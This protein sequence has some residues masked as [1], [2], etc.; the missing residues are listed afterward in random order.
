MVIPSMIA[1]LRQVEA[2]PLRQAGAQSTWEQSD[3]PILHA[4]AAYGPYVFA[5]ILAFVVIKALV[6]SHRYR[7]SA[8]LAP[9]VQKRVHDALIS[10]EQ[11]TIGEIVPVIVER[12]DSHPEARWLAALCTMLLGSALL[13]AHLPWHAPHWLLLCQVG[14]GAVGYIAARLLPDIARMFVLEERA[15]EVVE[16][17][18]FQEFHRLDL[19]KTEKST[20]VLIFVSLFEKRVLVLGDEGIDAK[21]GEE[22]WS[23][24]RDLVLTSIKRGSLTDGIAE[25]VRRCGDELSKYFPWQEGDRNEVPDR[26]VVRTS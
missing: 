5:A 8:A 26:F 25:A 6:N 22:H 18:A 19:H 15:S 12:S 3:N 17:Q 11:R 23:L 14:L 16:E 2:A 20:G 7:A 9:E 21:V 4:L 1:L 10:A 24:L 13:E